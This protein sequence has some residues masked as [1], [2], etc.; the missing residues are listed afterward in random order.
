M[1]GKTMF[2]PN[3]IITPGIA[4]DLMKIEAL[5][6][7]IDTL[8]INSVVLASLRETARIESIHYST[9]IEGN[10]LTSQEVKEVIEQSQHFPGRERDEKEVRGY[11][12]GLDYLENLLKKNVS[13]SEATIKTLHALVMGGGKKKVKA[14]PYRDGQNVIRDAATRR[15]VYLPPEAKDVFKLMKDLVI[16]INKIEKNFPC[17]LRAALVHYQFATVHPYFDGNGRTARLLTS[18]LLHVGGY[19][20][21]GLYALEE[22]YA[23]DLPAYYQAITI[24]SSHNYYLG[25][26]HADITPWLK[27]FC[28]GMV[29]SFEQVK[30]HALRAQKKGLQDSSDQLFQLNVRQRRALQLFKKKDF[31]TAYDVEKAFHVQ[32]RTARALCQQWVE[33]G[34]F[35]VVNPSKKKR[36]YSFSPSLKNS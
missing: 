12:V 5:R 18:F 31:I 11:Y 14:T 3:Y 33:N 23:K 8:P 2:K 16:W 30:L 35:V 19:G 7:E 32:P 26:E 36:L 15:I 1:A 21:N 13:V 29:H 22:Y 25:R 4:S 9:F 20:L 28:A 34:F 27:Y 6:Q 17:P 24:G 10:R